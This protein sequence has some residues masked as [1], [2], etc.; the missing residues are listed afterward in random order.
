MRN[1]APYSRL[2]AVSDILP[3]Q[4]VGILNP[5]GHLQDVLRPGEGS[6]LRKLREG[7]E[8]TLVLVRNSVL[9][10]YLRAFC[11]VLPTQVVGIRNPL[12]HL[13]D[14]LRL[15]APSCLHQSRAP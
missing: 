11:D 9:Y 5:L 12:G 1:F 6:R 14:V 4:M 2:L 13:P 7:N 8:R 10:S 15:G 3:A